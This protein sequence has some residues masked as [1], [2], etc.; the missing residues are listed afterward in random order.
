MEIDTVYY[1]TQSPV[2]NTNTDMN[3]AMFFYFLLYRNFRKRN[4]Y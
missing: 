3:I 4:I 1:I 2:H